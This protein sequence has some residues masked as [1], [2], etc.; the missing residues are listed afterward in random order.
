MVA[1]MFLV[2]KVVVDSYTP[3]LSL[4]LKGYTIF[5]DLDNY[6]FMMVN[7]SLYP[8]KISGICAI[9]TGLLVHVLPA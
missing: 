4:Y 6:L 9:A 5:L 7:V 8:P 3:L 1:L 2:Q